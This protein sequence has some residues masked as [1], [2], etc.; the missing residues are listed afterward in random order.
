MPQSSCLLF[1]LIVSNPHLLSLT[2]PTPFLLPSLTGGISFLGAFLAMLSAAGATAAVMYGVYHLHV[3]RRME[4]DLRSILEEY[5]PLSAAPQ[6]DPND[7][8]D[9]AST[10]TSG[11]SALSVCRADSLGR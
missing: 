4:E 11:F 2:H 3:R 7:P 1:T 10:P 8:G 9:Q 5:V 6:S